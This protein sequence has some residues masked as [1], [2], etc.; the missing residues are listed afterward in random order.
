[1]MFTTNVETLETLSGMVYRKIFDIVKTGLL[2]VVE[3]DGC[4][5]P[6]KGWQLAKPKEGM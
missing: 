3:I 1:M 6:L 5:G 2:V 4:P